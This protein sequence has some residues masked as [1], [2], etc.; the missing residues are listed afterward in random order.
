MPCSE[1]SRGHVEGIDGA[2]HGGSNL[3]GAGRVAVDADRQRALRMKRLRQRQLTA[4]Q[5]RKAA[6]L[7]HSRHSRSALRRV[8]VFV[9]A[10]DH[11]A[12]VLVVVEVGKELGY[13]VELV[14]RGGALV[15]R[16]HEAHER[17]AERLDG[18]RQRIGQLARARRHAVQRAMRLDVA[19]RHTLAEQ[20]A[21]QRT[22]LVPHHGQQFIGRDAH[23]TPAEALE[24]GQRRMG[25]YVH[26]VLLGQ[27]HRRAHDA[28]IRGVEAARDV[29]HRDVLHECR[30][31]AEAV[32]TKAFAHVGIDRYQ[33]M[34]HRSMRAGQVC[35]E[36]M[37]GERD[38][39][40]RHWRRCSVARARSHQLQPSNHHRTIDRHVVNVTQTHQSHTH[41]ESRRDR[42]ACDQDMQAARDR[43]CRHLLERGLGRA[44]REAR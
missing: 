3:S 12:A 36:W 21:G 1:L 19:E 33:P 40:V 25:A 37:D 15:L 43:E 18:E 32:D 38:S 30:V 7:E 31:V 5:C 16:A 39:R 29:G 10:R 6:G 4:A 34:I 27:Q 9:C 28:R 8:A 20:D 26:A 42:R 23:L 17:H 41:C 2:T 35:A 14:A 11:E 24:I 22:D 44:A 13:E